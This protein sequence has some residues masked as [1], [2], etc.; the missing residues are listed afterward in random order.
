MSY[1]PIA[2]PNWRKSRENVV[3]SLKNMTCQI[4]TPGV[5]S[6]I[7]RYVNALLE[8]A[9]KPTEYIPEAVEDARHDL[10]VIAGAGKGVAP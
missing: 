5:R 6:E 9:D 1:D 4:R 10:V 3:R 8:R 2:E 7:T